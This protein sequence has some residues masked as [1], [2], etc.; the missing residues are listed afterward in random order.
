[1]VQST[2]RYKFEVEGSSE[3]MRVLRFEG[4]EGISRLFE[5]EILLSCESGSVDFSQIVGQEALLT[6]V[7]DQEPRHVHGIISR[8][9]QEEEGKHFTAYRASVVPRAWKLLH[10]H[11]C[12]IFQRLSVPDIIRQVLNGAGLTEPHWAWALHNA[13]APKEYRVQYRE[14]DWAF[15]CRLMEEEGIIYYFDHAQDDHVLVMGDTPFAHKAIAGPSSVIYRQ[16]LGALTSGEHV[17]RFRYT[18]EVKPGKVTLRDYNFKN[19]NLLMEASVSA[20]LDDKLEVYDYPGEYDLP[21][22]AQARIKIRLEEWQSLRK[23]AQ[24]ESDCIRFTPGHVFELSDHPRDDYN[25][26][27]L[28]ISVEHRGSEPQFGENQEQAVAYSNRF[29]CIPADIPYRSPQITP[30]P[31]PRGVQTAIVV[32]PSG[33]EIYTDEHGRVKVQFHWDRQ[34]RRDENSSCWIRVSQ[35]WAGGAYGAMHIPRI[36]HEVIVDFLEGDPDRPIIVGRVYHG[37]NVPPYPLPADKTRSTLRSDSSPGSG[38]SNEIR[39]ED[40]KEKEEIYVHA[41]KDWTIVVE[42]DKNQDVGR[43]E[44]LDVVKNRNKTVGKDQTEAIGANKKISVG[45]DHDETIGR[46]QVVKIDH[47][48]KLSIANDLTEAIGNNKK[49]EVQ[50]NHE[51]SIGQDQKIKIGKDHELSVAGAS[52]TEVKGKLDVTIGGDMSTA[53]GGDQAEDVGKKKKITVGEKITIECGDSKITI[54]KDGK[55]V[56]EGSDIKVKSSGPVKVEASEMEVKSSGNIN[57]KGTNIK[58]KGSAIDMN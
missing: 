7:H 25:Q 8:F 27:L 34:G 16:S 33:E 47:D 30:K 19:P 17:S 2:E 43:N 3:S 11:D 15:L 1:M 4:R 56:V 40:Q 21:G 22:D 26:K 51:E 48:S 57:V 9:D 39:F 23:T 18:E 42:N 10:R 29:Q 41:Q 6:L 46:D 52:T 32:G 24:G 58:V 37:T 38:G 5:F 53:V 55:I 45:N 14:S 49:V 36:G 13:Y 28:L 31:T 50:T 54:S 12:R 35:V 20:P 44:T